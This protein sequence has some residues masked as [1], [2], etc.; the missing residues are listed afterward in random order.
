MNASVTLLHHVTAEADLYGRKILSLLRERGPAEGA[1][2]S[3]LLA[4]PF[5]T[6]WVTLR[7][8][9]VFS[10]MDKRPCDEGRTA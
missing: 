9:W 3:S 6:Q 10:H 4:G 8:G 2:R 5:P 1:E 7:S